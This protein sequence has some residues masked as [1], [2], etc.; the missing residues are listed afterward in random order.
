MSWTSHN[1]CSYDEEKRYLE[2]YKDFLIEDKGVKHLDALLL[3]SSLIT[4]TK[5]RSYFFK[6]VD[7]GKYKQVYYYNELKLKNEKNLESNKKIDTTYLFKKEN[8]NRKNEK[9]FI[10]FKNVNRTKFN[11]QRLVKANEDEFKTFITLTFDEDVKDIDIANKRFR[12]WR[13]I[14]Q[15]NFKDFKYICVPEFQ[16]ND[17]VH[18]HLLTNLSYNDIYLI[19]ENI[20][21]NKLLLKIK[22][23]KYILS[24]SRLKAILD[25]CI[26]L[27]EINVVLRKIDGKLHNTKKTYNF[28][29]KKYKIFKT[30]K[31][32]NNGFSSILNLQSINVVGYITK[33]LTKDIDNRLFGR[34]KY[35]HSQNLILPKEYYI[36]CKNDDEFYYYLDFI[37]KSNIVYQKDY[38]DIFENV[39]NFVEY[40]D[41][42]L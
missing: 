38:L 22:S 10:E 9:K 33:Y 35:F 28:K 3:D 34:R 6:V 15:R 37:N 13:D 30:V 39:I 40:K 29:S 41:N 12:Y 23:N 14:F 20:F 36:D 2:E 42:G 1:Y 7:C 16:K 18:Y 5:T 11:L 31:Y 21:Y 25:N 4:T 17:R 26:K 27:N 24:K 8:I 19:N 32:W